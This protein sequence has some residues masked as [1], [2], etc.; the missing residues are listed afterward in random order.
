MFILLILAFCI[1]RPFPHSHCAALAKFVCTPLLK[2]S[3]YLDSLY[4]LLSC[5]NMVKRVRLWKNTIRSASCTVNW[6]ILEWHLNINSLGPCCVGQPG[7]WLA[8]R[9]GSWW[10]SWSGPWTGRW[11]PK[12]CCTEG[13]WVVVGSH[14]IIL[15]LVHRGLCVV[16]RHPS[17][18]L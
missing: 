14:G 17:C 8:S 4:R 16:V 11:S 3:K 7:T 5:Y 13:W 18:S 1:R 9:L 10:C 6:I 15:L 2:K 12:Y